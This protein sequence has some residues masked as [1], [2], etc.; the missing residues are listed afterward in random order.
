MAAIAR[1][2]DGDPTATVRVSTADEF[3]VLASHFNEMLARIHQFND[4]LEAKV[5]EATAEL[6][7]R[8]QEVQRLNELLFRMQRSLS[9]A[10]RLA[11]SGRIMA[12]V[13]HEVGTPLH[14][15]AGHLEILRKDLP[16]DLLSE[17]IR[18]RLGII[19]SQLTRSTEII[20]QLLDLTRRSPGEPG[21][22][23]INQLIRDT[24][25]LVRPGLATAGLTLQVVADPGPPTARGHST[26]LQQV[27]LNLLTNAMDATPAGGRIELITRTFLAQGQ[28]G[29]EV[30]DT[31][32]GI[33]LVHQKQIFDPF[34]STKEPGRGT[35]LGLFISAQIVRDHQGRIEVESVE[36]RGSTFR[37]FLPAAGGPR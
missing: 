36:G 11:L 16:P 25:D 28:V 3:G 18:R 31:G 37:V 6:D 4:E 29:V 14:S 26:Q 35:G 33:P 24:A 12:E 23:D 7:R 22:V 30:S 34:F 10:E 1:V 19:E 32:C 5:K 8:Y 21:P 9:H 2:R 15:V 13:A 27:V 17:D 20:A